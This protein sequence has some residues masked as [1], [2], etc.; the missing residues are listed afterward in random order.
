MVHKRCSDARS[1]ENELS[2]PIEVRQ[3]NAGRFET[4]EWGCHF[5]EAREQASVIAGE[6]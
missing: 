5:S 1:R 4:E 6:K 2:I 3:Y